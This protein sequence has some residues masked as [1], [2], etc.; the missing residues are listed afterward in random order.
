[1]QPLIVPQ[2][3][4]Q[5]GTEQGHGAVGEVDNPRAP[6]DEH[7]TVGAEGVQRPGAETEKHKLE[8]LSHGES[9]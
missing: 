4:E 7:D 9:P 5:R 3:G 2:F 8:D 1:M 6:V